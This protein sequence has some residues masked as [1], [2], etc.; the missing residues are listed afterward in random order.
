MW[1]QVVAQSPG[2][3]APAAEVVRYDLGWKALNTMLKAGRSLS[4]HERNCC[5]LNTRGERFA[6]VS[7]AAELDYDDDGRVVA[8]SDWDLDGDLDFWI[9]NRSG[10]QVRFLRNDA[11]NKH[12][13]LA[14]RLSGTRCNRD[15]VGARVELRLGDDPAHP[16]RIRTLRAGE[17]YLAQSSKWIHFGLGESQVVEQVVIRWPDGSQDILGNISPDQRYLIRQAEQGAAEVQVWQA[18]ARQVAL[19]PSVIK[20][21]PSTDNSRI[22]LISPVPIPSIQYTARETR[23]LVPV[24]SS[25]VGDNPTPRPARLVNLWATWCQ[26]C[27]AELREWTTHARQLQQAGVEVIA[28][29]VDEPVEDRA[30]QF[31]AID[32]VVD[33]LQL[34]FATGYGTMDLVNQFDVL[35]RAILSRQNPLPVPSSF[36]IDEQGNLR[37]IYKGP[38]EVSQ[39]VADA[40]LLHASAA[41]IVAASVP[42]E[43]IWLGQPAGSSPNQVAIKFVEGGL[44]D[45]AED[46][47][48]MLIRNS[49]AN[50]MYSPADAHA[51]LG[52]IDLDKG[53]YETAASSFAAALAIDNNHRQAHIELADIL[54]RQRKPAQAAGHYQAALERR[55]DDPE[56]HLK[57]GLAWLEQGDQVA[58]AGEFTESNRLRPSAAAHHHLGNIRVAEGRHEDAVAHFE[59]VLELDPRFSAAANNL[60][61]LFATRESVLAAARAVTIAEQLCQT[62]SARTAGNLDTLAAAYAAAGRFDEAIQA[63]TEAIRTAKAAGD[64]GQSS[65]IQKRLQL[66]RRNQPFRE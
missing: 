16:L 53:R 48:H 26:P 61:W 62:T 9:A 41:D 57:L 22:V 4:G 31:A 35:Q 21:P 13:F 2:K 43:G 66:Y 52:A 63:A 64:V 65:R 15:A 8:L 17:G 23:Q 47:L 20:V 33:A 12:H 19:T 40:R 5:F 27:L 58:A 10:P 44:I 30:G 14:F 1:R 46:Y 60:A 32:R 11:Q 54:M 42:Y 29:N 7:A 6:D 50:P 56:L 18:P 37:V 3:N 45:Q 34:P 59:A 38:I 55:S 28:V 25:A 49:S 51:L 39:V 36:L 24:T